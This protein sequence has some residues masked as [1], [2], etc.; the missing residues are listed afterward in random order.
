MSVKCSVCGAP[1]EQGLKYCPS[2]GAE[3]APP[4]QQTHVQQQGY[5]QQAYV[6]QPQY[7]QPQYQQP[8]YSAQPQFAAPPQAPMQPYPQQIQYAGN[9]PVRFGIPAPGWS[10]RVNH[11]EI[12]A[13]IKKQ[14]HYGSCF[15]FFV[16]PLPF[17]GFVIYSIVTGEMELSQAALYGA[18]VSGIFLLFT[19]FGKASGSKSNS[20]EATVVDRFKQ[21]EYVR[22]E[23]DSRHGPRSETEGRSYGIT[24]VKTTDGRTKKIK[25]ELGSFSRSFAWEYL[26]IG[27]RFRYHPQFTGFPYERYDK[28]AYPYLYCV[29]CRTKNN[30][31]DDRCKKCNAPLL[32]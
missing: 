21:Q 2:C 31:Q 17:F 22:S 30:L 13:K 23:T 6:Q 28:A 25:E 11:P 18:I 3:I 29:C 4:Q 8:Q 24:V 7:Q 32:K 5:P 26:Q 15:A 1:I 10:D 14:G 16:I 27:D 9:G 20:Y 12:T 19:I